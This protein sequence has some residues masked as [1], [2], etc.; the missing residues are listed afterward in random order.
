M[1]VQSIEIMGPEYVLMLGLWWGVAVFL[2]FVFLTARRAFINWRQRQGTG[3][4]SAVV[5]N[6]IDA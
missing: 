1:N 3:R 2:T 6:Q 5:N 4:M